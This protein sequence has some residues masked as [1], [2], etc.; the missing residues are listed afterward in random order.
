[1][2]ASPVLTDIAP[3]TPEVPGVRRRDRHGT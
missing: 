2:V 1:L 3:L